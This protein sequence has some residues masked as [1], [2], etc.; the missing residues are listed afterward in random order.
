MKTLKESLLGDLEKNV[1]V[2]TSDMY[3]DMY[4]VPKIKDFKKSI[5][6]DYHIQ[7]QC[8]DIIQKYVNILNLNISD[9]YSQDITGFGIHIYPKQSK[10]DTPSENIYLLYND[11]YE[12]VEKNYSIYGVGCDNMTIPQIKKEII[13]FFNAVVENP[14]LIK[15]LFE[16]SEKRKK[17][18]DNYGFCDTKTLKEILKF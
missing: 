6:G 2:T 3:R 16:Y 1:S 5:L 7:W 14:D 18:I 10:Y 12:L 8:K 4:K 15:K 17:E 9:K 13:E 11:G